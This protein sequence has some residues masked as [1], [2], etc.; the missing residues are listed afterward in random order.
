[1]IQVAPGTKVHLACRPVSSQHALRLRWAV[2]QGR[3]GVSGGIG[4]DRLHWFGFGIERG[5]AESVAKTRAF[6]C[7]RPSRLGGSDRT[8]FAI[9]RSS[10]DSRGA[11][12]RPPSG[13][14]RTRR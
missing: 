6:T 9:M 12:R 11:P 5:D 3:L 13:P 10:Q 8:F 4:A 2:R 7:P 14:Q 1:M